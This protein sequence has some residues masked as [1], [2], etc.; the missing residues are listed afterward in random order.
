MMSVEEIWKDAFCAVYEM[1]AAMKVFAETSPDYAGVNEDPVDFYERNQK[2]PEKMADYVTAYELV[3]KECKTCEAK[4]EDIENG[5]LATC[6]IN[7]KFLDNTSEI[8]H[9]SV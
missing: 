2:N 9:V 4:V 3:K 5:K 7:Q 6:K 1:E 8:L